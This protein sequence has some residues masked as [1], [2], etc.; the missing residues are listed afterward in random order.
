[1]QAGEVDKS[2][3]SETM[4]VR[5]ESSNRPRDLC[6]NDMRDGQL[7]I[8]VRWSYDN[9][10]LGRIVQRCKDVII[11]LGE[12]S[13]SSHTTVLNNRNEDCR[14]RLLETGEKIV[15]ESN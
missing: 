2:E 6:V 15:V 9:C 1:M 3:R 7:G 10:V 14:V 5:I 4:S 8:V 12:S 11:V 13:G